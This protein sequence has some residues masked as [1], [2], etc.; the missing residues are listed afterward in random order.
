[1]LP[2]EIRPTVP[3][4]G[5]YDDC[6]HGADESLMTSGAAEALEETKFT[7]GIE[8]Y[9]IKMLDSISKIM[10]LNVVILHQESF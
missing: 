3:K 6:P 1:M 9:G 10:V 7:H 2:R 8:A 4:K 5:T